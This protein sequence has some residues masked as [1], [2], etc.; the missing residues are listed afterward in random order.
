M[1]IQQTVCLFPETK[2]N[3][4]VDDNDKGHDKGHSVPYPKTTTDKEIDKRHSK[5]Q[6]VLNKQKQQKKI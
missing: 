6:H 4:S 5:G 1:N 2:L 3:Q